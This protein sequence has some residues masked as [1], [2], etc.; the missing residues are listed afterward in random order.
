MGT[1]I[2]SFILVA[3][4]EASSSLTRPK[5]GR[6]GQRTAIDGKLSRWGRGTKN[7]NQYSKEDSSLTDSSLSEEESC[8]SDNENRAMDHNID[9]P[10]MC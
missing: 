6:P 4:E 5:S 7:T 3:S 10:G 9:I 8:S 2:R 1:I